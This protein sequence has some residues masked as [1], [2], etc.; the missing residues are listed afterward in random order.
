V[1]RLNQAYRLDWS[2]QT[3]VER[4]HV[5]DSVGASPTDFDWSRQSIMPI[6]P[7]KQGRAEFA[8][9]VRTFDTVGHIVLSIIFR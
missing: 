2:D 7:Y 9:A 6:V 5:D 3:C 4:M 1:F 8:S